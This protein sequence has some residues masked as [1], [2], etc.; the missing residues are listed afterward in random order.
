LLLLL[1]LGIS[2]LKAKWLLIVVRRRCERLLLLLVLF[3]LLLL[4]LRGYPAFFYPINAR[5]FRWLFCFCSS[6]YSSYSC[7]WFSIQRRR[8]RR[9]VQ[10]WWLVRVGG[11]VRRGVLKVAV[12]TLLRLFSVSTTLRVQE[13]M[14]VYVLLK[15]G[16]LGGGQGPVAALPT[17]GARLRKGGRVHARP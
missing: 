5:Y 17:T 1:L 4:L 3:L 7:T 16:L 9:R 15:M 13:V 8:T 11:R 12:L 10:R 6:C 14:A 2:R